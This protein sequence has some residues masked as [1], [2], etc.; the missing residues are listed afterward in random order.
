MLFRSL[1]DKAGKKMTELDRAKI[2]GGM[3]GHAGIHIHAWD[4]TDAEGKPVAPG[5]YTVRW[6]FN[7]K[8]REFPV[9]LK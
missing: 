1:Y 9:T 5:E 2:D 7:G 3:D 4:R 8:H 6:T